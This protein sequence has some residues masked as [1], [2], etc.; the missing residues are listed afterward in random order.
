MGY[1]DQIN[2]AKTVEGVEA[3]KAE[4][5][6]A[7]AEKTEDDKKPSLDDL[8]DYDKI[9]DLAN[10]D[11]DKDISDLFDFS[12]IK[13]EAEKDPENKE[14]WD[15][16]I[17]LIK[18][19]KSSKEFLAAL[20]KDQDKFAKLFDFSKVDKNGKIKEVNEVKEVKEAKKENKKV[21]NVNTGV[22]GLTGVV[23]TL[24]AAESISEAAKSAC[25]APESI[26]EAAKSACEAAESILE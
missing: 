11:D 1:F 3:L 20:E 12:K 16:F 9:K 13:E 15:E 25:E 2:K 17:K 7:H 10:K 8:F 24:E 18:D 6:K 4:I 21:N 19:D 22:A 26:S 14:I 5:L 23:A